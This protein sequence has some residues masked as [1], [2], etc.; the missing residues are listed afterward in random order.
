[1]QILSWLSN[2]AQCNQKGLYKR[3]V[4]ESKIERDVKTE[5]ECQ[6]HVT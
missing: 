5:A 4:K 3:K 1:M 2:C 6:S